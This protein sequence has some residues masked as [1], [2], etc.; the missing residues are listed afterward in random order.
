MKLKQLDRFSRFENAVYQLLAYFIIWGGAP[1]LAIFLVDA[2]FLKEL[3]PFIRYPLWAILGLVGMILGFAV[4]GSVEAFFTGIRKT[5][6]MKPLRE[7]ETEMADQRGE[8]ELNAEERKL[9][10]FTERPDREQRYMLYL[11]QQQQLAR[12]TEIRA[13]IEI[14]KLLLIGVLAFYVISRLF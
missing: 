11:L 6:G 10:W 5:F 12:L 2:F 9:R 1:L 3:S 7:I 13:S 14:I 8:A 4:A